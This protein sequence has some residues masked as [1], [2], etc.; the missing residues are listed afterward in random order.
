MK[1][2]YQLSNLIAFAGI[3]LASP[4]AHGQLF[5]DDFES[6]TAGAALDTSGPW[7]I[8][9]SGGSAVIISDETT[10]TPFGTPNQYLDLN[11]NSA[12]SVRIQSADIT[13]ASGA[14]T[15]FAFDFNEPTSA[16][17]GSVNFGYANEGLDLLSA[18]TRIASSLSDGTI[19]GLSGGT[20]MYDLDTSY[21][22]YM[23]FNDTAAGV[24]YNGGSNT[25]AS[26]TADFWL[27]PSGGTAVF[28]GSKSIQQ[29]QTPSYGIAFRSF[30]SVE[31]QI[32]VDNVALF[33]GVALP[34][35]PPTI[36]STTPS[37]DRLAV[38]AS[39]NLIA[40]FNIP[41]V[42][43]TGNI[44]IKESVGD[45][46]VATIAITDAAVTFSGSSITV[47]LPSDLAASTAYYVLIDNGAIVDASAAGNVFAGIVAPDATSWNFTTGIAAPQNSADSIRGRSQ[48]LTPTYIVNS[49]SG[50]VG[51]GGGG[52]NRNDFNVV[53][54]F[55]LPTLPAGETVS[56]ATFDFEITGSRE[57]ANNP[58]LNVYLLDTEDPDSSGISLFYHGPSDPSA[59]VAFVGA[60]NLPDSGMNLTYAADEQDQ[61]YTLSGDALALLQSYYGG[62]NVPDRTEAFF[63]FNL[64]Q[65]LGGATINNFE[66]YFISTASDQSL[67]TIGSAVGAV[68]PYGSW[69]AGF[70][71]N[72]GATT[73]NPDA[74]SLENLLEFAFG[75]DPNVSDALPL[76]A[77]G[78]VNGL[79]IAQASGGAGGVT[80]DFVFVRRDDHGTSGSVTY[81]PQFSDDLM[82]FYDSTATPTMVA[83]STADAS[84]E[85]VS[86]PY[87]FLLSN[88]K[89]P[90][91]ARVRVEINP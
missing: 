68:P 30:G 50:Q 41:V 2:T 4:A 25:V 60:T 53:L 16:L 91:Y 3:A 75:T 62:D 56:S 88:G 73:D 15:T 72:P 84:Y 80:F 29:A 81:T 9:G 44:L 54:G 78:S 46:T 32:L 69:A 58:A 89:K 17:A 1:Q 87:P 40:N 48:A 28:A 47:D 79:P 22:L 34:G 26:E 90:R 43:G 49:T 82:T 6:Y 45:A 67:L 71:P 85:V 13:A 51:I 31:Q 64:D 27:I 14:V 86:V 52:G 12:S 66:R 63:R 23:I 36:Q 21:R 76:V 59:D 61:S 7:S 42:A 39:T 19:G 11:D 37:D 65:L 77:D 70:T 57:V 74:D 83:D 18:S 24:S 20:N 8:A 38:V 55:T 35:N 33:E 10:A 5:S